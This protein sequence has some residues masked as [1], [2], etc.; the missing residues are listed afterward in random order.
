[1]IGIKNIAGYVCSKRINNMDKVFA[2]GEKEDAAFL[3]KKLGILATSSKNEDE[4]T[5]DLCVNAYN[6]LIL[7]EEIDINKVDCLCVCTQSHDYITPHTS[8]VVQERLNISNSCAVFDINMGCGG[9]VYSLSI[10]K[11]FMEANGLKCGLLFNCDTFT[12]KIDKNDRNAGLVFGDA[13]SVTLLTEDYLFSIEKPLFRSDRSLYGALVM[14][15]DYDL[16]LNSIPVFSFIMGNIP[17]LVNN[18]LEKNSLSKQDIDIFA[19]QQTGKYILDNLSRRMKIADE[20]MPFIAKDYGNT[21]SASVSLI[22]EKYLT[23]NNVNKILVCGF[24]EGLAASAVPIV[25]RKN[26]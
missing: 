8:A 21:S 22:V 16:T 19:F 18:V 4:L 20:K 13:S 26:A 9:Y 12:D 3:E 2:N 23:D 10:M 24:G 6:N 17:E 5:S 7:K 11:S 15:K 14:K 25:R 1:M